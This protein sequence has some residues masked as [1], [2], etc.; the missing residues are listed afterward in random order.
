MS[1]KEVKDMKST[2][3]KA[4]AVLALIACVSIGDNVTT[5]DATDASIHAQDQM[6]HPESEHEREHGENNNEFM[7]Q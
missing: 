1:T 5:A 3:A 7:R 4:L 2:I 6:M